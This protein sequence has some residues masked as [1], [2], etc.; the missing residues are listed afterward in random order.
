MT[1]RERGAAS[2]LPLTEPPHPAVCKGRG[3]FWFQNPSIK[4]ANSQQNLNPS[5]KS[6][7]YPEISPV[8]KSRQ[9]I[10]DPSQNHFPNTPIVPGKK[11]DRFQDTLAYCQGAY[12]SR[13]TSMAP[14]MGGSPYWAY[15]HGGPFALPVGLARLGRERM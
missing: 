4:F 5:I 3:R 15:G 6:R 9:L 13:E 14:P 1:K 2:W 12:V 7:H 11:I 8:G 10:T